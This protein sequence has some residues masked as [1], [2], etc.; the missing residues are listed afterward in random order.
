MLK[1]R[2][3]VVFAAALPLAAAVAEPVRLDTGLV[4]GIAGANPEVRVFKGIPFAAPPVGDL[5]WRAPKPAAKWE[6]VRNAAEFGST[7][8]QRGAATPTTANGPVR[9][10][11]EDCLYLNVYTAA[12]S[13]NDKR[14]VMVWIHGGSLTSGAGSIYNGEELTKKGVVV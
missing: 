12:G 6:G 5:R 11:S 9:A 3:A 14:P 7:C 4:A 13:A 1:L 8:M 10:M 2:A